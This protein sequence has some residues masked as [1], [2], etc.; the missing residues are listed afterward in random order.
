[1]Q[2]LSGAKTSV[3]TTLL[4]IIVDALRILVWQNTKDGKR[5]RNKPES[6]LEMIIGPEK[7]EEKLGSFDT[8]EEFN[9]WRASMLG[10]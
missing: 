9:K 6:I 8:P 4:A 7:E 2:M 3:E 1:M 5:G 10:E